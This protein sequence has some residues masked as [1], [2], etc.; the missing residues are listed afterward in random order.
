MKFVTNRTEADVI[1]RRAKGCY[2]YSDLNRVEGNVE[3]LCHMAA[4]IGVEIEVTTKTDWGT[5]GDFDTATWPTEIQ[6]ARYLK[7]VKDL[8]TALGLRVRLPESMR[9]LTV[10]GANDIEIALRAAYEEI[11][12]RME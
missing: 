9:H 7:N 4:E 3:T 8:C 5:P 11:Q 1:L 12:R 6:M 10:A 2:S